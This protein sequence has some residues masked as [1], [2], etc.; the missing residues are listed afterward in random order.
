MQISH[1]MLL[2][3]NCLS[4][5]P[6]IHRY[7]PRWLLLTQIIQPI[8]HLK[9]NQYMNYHCNLAYDVPIHKPGMTRINLNLAQSRGY[10]LNHKK[11]NDKKHFKLL[12]LL[13]FNYYNIRH[14][15]SVLF[16]EQ[17]NYER[18]NTKLNKCL[19]ILYV[20]HFLSESSPNGWILSSVI[21]FS[22]L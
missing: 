5:N 17:R 12:F 20:E 8:D 22:I 18:I 7:S 14:N 3:S 13:I 4:M 10:F 2:N 15:K 1:S 19:M 21:W 16:P 6:L 9:H 11:I